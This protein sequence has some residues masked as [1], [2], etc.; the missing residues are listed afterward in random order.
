MILQC[1]ITE[2]EGKKRGVSTEWKKAD[3]KEK[4]NP[5]GI[6]YLNQKTIIIKN[7]IC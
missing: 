6:T 7:I 4:R 1:L 5:D 2:E 3:T